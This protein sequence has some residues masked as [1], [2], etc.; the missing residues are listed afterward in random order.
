VRPLAKWLSR[1]QNTHYA[2]RMFQSREV[3]WEGINGRH[4]T[5]VMLMDGY[6]HEHSRPI[7]V[8]LTLFEMWKKIL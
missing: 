1:M 8:T 2:N 5:R 7:W 4:E 3:G 6:Y